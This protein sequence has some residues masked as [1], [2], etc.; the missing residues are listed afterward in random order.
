MVHYLKGYQLNH[1]Y[2]R[3]KSACIEHTVFSIHFGCLQLAFMLQIVT[4]VFSY[5]ERGFPSSF[6]YCY[7]MFVNWQVNMLSTNTVLRQP[8]PWL[9]WLSGSQYFSFHSFPFPPSCKQITGFA[10]LMFL[11]CA[12]TSCTYLIYLGYCS[13]KQKLIFL[14]CCILIYHLYLPI[15][16]APPF[17][18]CWLLLPSRHCCNLSLSH[19]YNVISVTFYHFTPESEF[20]YGFILDLTYSALHLH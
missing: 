4:L 10:T 19:N 2:C 9:V 16:F 15:N 11:C 12:R 14:K 1:F 7:G 18:F 8:F 3:S 13:I 6:L 5:A 20:V 17:F